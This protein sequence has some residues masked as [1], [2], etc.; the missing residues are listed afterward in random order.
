[1]SKDHRNG[2]KQQHGNSRAAYFAS[3]KLW[4]AAENKRRRIEKAARDTAKKR[5]RHDQVRDAR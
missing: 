2:G 1:M 3:R 4:R 5:Q